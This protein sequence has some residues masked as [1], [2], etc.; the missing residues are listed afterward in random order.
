[1]VQCPFPHESTGKISPPQSHLG[2]AH[3]YPHVGEC[4]LPLHV[5]AVACTMHN[6]ALQKCCA[7][8]PDVT[9]C[10]RA[11]RDVTERYGS[12]TG[13]FRALWNI[14]EHCRTLWNV[15]ETLRSVVERYATLRSVVC[16][17]CLLDYCHE[18]H[19]KGFLQ[20]F[21]VVVIVMS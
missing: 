9:E 3:R 8:L 7:S 10:Y 17:D 11:L 14:T 18:E 19:R 21:V 16:K 13:C 12:V 1:M 5:L 15:T 6:E 2:R 20:L 4:S